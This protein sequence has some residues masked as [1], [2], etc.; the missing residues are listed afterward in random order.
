MVR[1][2]KRH[3]RS[4]GLARAELRKALALWGLSSV[5][6]AAVLVLSELV[7]NAVRH[8]HVPAGREVETRF[9]ALPGGGVR[10]EVHDAC[11]RRPEV[12][13]ASPGACAGRGLLIVEAVA[14]SW[15]VAGRDGVGKAV[16]A[17]VSG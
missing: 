10:L 6:E 1:R 3:A 15:G 8:A 12:Q 13:D 7:T 5:E 9:L 4:V 17:V 16:W 2:W 11:S 14:D